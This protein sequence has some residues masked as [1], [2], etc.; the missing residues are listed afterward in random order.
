ME[1][2]LLGKH[3]GDERVSDFSPPRQKFGGLTNP[4]L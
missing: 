4:D 1:W 2:I 3:T